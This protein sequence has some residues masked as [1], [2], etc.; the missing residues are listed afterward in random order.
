MSADEFDP[1]VERLFGQTPPMADSIHFA[2]AVEQRLIQGSRVRTLALSLAG[3]IGGVIAVRETVG[4]N[5]QFRASDASPSEA[6][7]LAETGLT[8]V[9]A[10]AQ[11]AVQSGL[12]DLGL[13]MDLSSM[14][15]MQMFWL[16]SAILI[17]A[18]AMAAT[19]LVQ[20]I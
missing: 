5:L 17:G 4:S 3:L 1:Y 15:G 18:A 6:S 19:K 12:T 7:R 11:S 20:D 10:S 14:A 13:A 2:A 9:S 16:A 8:S